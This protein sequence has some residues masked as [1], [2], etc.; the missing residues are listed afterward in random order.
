MGQHWKC[1]FNLPFSFIKYKKMYIMTNVSPFRLVENISTLEEEPRTV[2]NN[3]K[4]EHWLAGQI[5]SQNAY[6]SILLPI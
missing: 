1:L 6:F 3:N 4:L 2:W 5:G